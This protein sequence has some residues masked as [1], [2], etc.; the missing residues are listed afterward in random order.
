MQI[1]LS[2]AAQVPV[3]P[4][5]HL[6]PP[7][8]T[9]LAQPPLELDE[10]PELT[11]VPIIPGSQPPP[12][13]QPACSFTQHGDPDWHVK[14]FPVPQ[15][16]LFGSLFGQGGLQ[17]AAM[18]FSP[19][20]ELLAS[21]SQHCLWKAPAENSQINF[22][23]VGGQVFGCPFGHGRHPLDGGQPVHIQVL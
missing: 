11:H 5:Q 1:K 6:I 12:V 14:T 9:H 10:P 23:L 16:I 21:F 4:L 7:D 17:F 19:P 18:Q 22:G 20:L 3:N 13:P 8:E 2:P 15:V